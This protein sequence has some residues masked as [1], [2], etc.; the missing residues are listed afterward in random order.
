MKGMS[1]FMS[2]ETLLIVGAG[3]A[4]RRAAESLRRLDVNV[5]I[6]LVG[7]ETEIPY[8]R[9]VLSKDAL[10][11]VEGEARAFIRNASW[12]DENRIDMRLGSR[13]AAI[14]RAARCVTLDDGTRL[15]YA[16]LLLATGSRVRRYPGELEEGVP[17]HYVRTLADARGLRDALGPGKRVAVLGGGFIGL[18]VAAAAVQR[19]CTVTLLEA[20]PG[21]LLRS[22]P[23]EVGAFLQ[24][25]HTARGVDIRFDTRAQHIR[26]GTT[27]TA[28]V[29]TNHGD[30]TAD[31]V[32]VG[33]GVVP[34]VELAAAAGL[35]I[36]NGIVVDQGCRT[37]DPMI[38]AAGEVTSHLN[39]LLGRHIRIESWQV[40]ENQPAIAAANMLGGDE[41]YAELP[42]LWSDQY[43]C[44]IQTLGVFS[45]TQL[46]VV[47]GDPAGRAFTV[48][49]LGAG[50]KLEALA[51]VNTGR[52]VAACRRLIKAD[53]IL[54]PITLADEATPL[55]NLL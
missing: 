33:I 11:S 16:R 37:A 8:D 40:A 18:E 29:A 9:P 55:R 7:E 46:K 52:D 41:H 27:G 34:N 28:I 22:M 10:S 23:L 3:H 47:R 5:P 1:K 14:D 45:D 2:N 17:L 39:P 30:V 32:V 21:L 31:V 24:A 43:D 25:L 49:A 35:E 13:V 38:F 26:K 15:D 4:A 19:G 48:L 20:A 6:C 42:W 51:A 12:Y 54:D 44:N 36:D 50:G 53:K